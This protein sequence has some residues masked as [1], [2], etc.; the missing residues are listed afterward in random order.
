MTRRDREQE[1]HM[2]KIFSP[3]DT[4]SLRT[5]TQSTVGH[6][7]E[8]KMHEMQGKKPLYDVDVQQQ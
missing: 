5:G 8:R 3:T 2:A 6:T 7:A 1:T 4:S